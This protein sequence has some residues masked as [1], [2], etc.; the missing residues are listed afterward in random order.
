MDL[1]QK[2]E[3][4]IEFL[5]SPDNK[6]I[7]IKGENLQVGTFFDI[8]VSNSKTDIDFSI[9][10]EVLNINEAIEILTEVTTNKD[11]D[12]IRDELIKHL[13]ST[14]VKSDKEFFLT[15]K[16]NKGTDRE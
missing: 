2:K 15:I 4:I 13:D 6:L 12:N 16:G 3:S 10:V 9:C 14:G 7:R 11:P 8:N 1:Q 5:S